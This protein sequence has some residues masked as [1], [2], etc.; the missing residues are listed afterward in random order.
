[1]TTLTE[2]VAKREA[3]QAELDKVD[4]SI[5]TRTDLPVGWTIDPGNGLMAGGVTLYGTGFRHNVS[6]A[7]E[8]VS[9]SICV[10]TGAQYGSV[11]FIKDHE[12]MCRSLWIDPE[13][14]RAALHIYDIQ[15]EEREREARRKERAR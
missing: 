5:A 3:L 1:M 4:E 12:S 8:E 14:V 10:S 6:H 2:M 7:D 15:N 11:F 13:A 9:V